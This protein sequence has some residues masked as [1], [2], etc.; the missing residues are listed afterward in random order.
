MLIEN[1]NKNMENIQMQLQSPQ[2]FRKF[3]WT[4]DFNVYGFASRG[5]MSQRMEKWRIEEARLQGKGKF[6]KAL[7]DASNLDHY[8]TQS[9]VSE[10][11]D[12]EKLVPGYRRGPSGQMQQDPM[13]Y[14]KPQPF[15]SAQLADSPVAL[16][17]THRSPQYQARQRV[18]S[19][20][21]TK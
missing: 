4:P 11:A 5:E 10:R 14:S 15:G 20:E 21:L 18:A 19:Q 6:K 2:N 12:F 8:N 16:F 13:P 9:S 17:S 7:A 3:F 1:L